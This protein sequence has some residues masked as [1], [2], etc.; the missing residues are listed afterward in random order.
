M[1][2]LI[3]SSKDSDGMSIGFARDPNGRQRELTNNKNAKGKYHLRFMLK[4]DFGFAEQEEKAIFG[5]GYKLTLATNSDSAVLS[6]D[7]A[8]INTPIK[9]KSIEWH[10]PHYTPSLN[11]QDLISNQT[12]SRTVVELQYIERSV[13]MEEVKYQKKMNFQVGT[14]E[15]V[16]ISIFLTIGFNYK[17]DKANKI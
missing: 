14:Q 2:K 8:I 7:N 10:V 1:C 6:K 12:L 11:E 4:D 5:L 3:T 15:G 13:F 9:I 17:I 16:N